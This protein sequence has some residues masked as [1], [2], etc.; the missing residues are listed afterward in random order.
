MATFTRTDSLGTGAA[1]GRSAET[2][3]TSGVAGGRTLTSPVIQPVNG[4]A[5]AA[6]FNQ[7][8]TKYSENF[9]PFIQK[10]SI[11]Q[12]RF[13]HDRIPR[14]A[15]TLFSGASKE[16]RIFRGG[17]V[18]YAGLAHWGD[19]VDYASA[20]GSFNGQTYPDLMPDPVTYGYS[21]EKLQW[22]GK[23]MA[24]AS[25]PIHQDMFRFTQE[26]QTQLA[27]ILQSGID[28]AFSHQE[29]WNRDNYIYAAVQSG[30]AFIMAPGGESASV[31]GQFYYN[32]YSYGAANVVDTN[33]HPIYLSTVPHIVF[34]VDQE[35]EPLNF[36]VLD[37]AHDALSVRA[38][39]GGIGMDSGKPVFGLPI[40][41][42][43]FEKYV[44]G[45]AAELEAWRQ[46]YPQELIK[47]YGM[48]LKNYRY[49]GLVEDTNQ[50]RFKI[51]KVVTAEQATWAGITI[52]GNSA[53]TKLWVAEYVA[54]R[55]LGRNSTTSI[56]VPEENMDYIKAELAIS[57]IFMNNVFT[58]Q[59]VPA[60]P[61]LGSGTSF[62]A[63]PGLNGNWGWQN[64]LDKTTNPH[65]KVGNFYGT[66]EIFP[67]P[68]SNF[69]NAT[70]FLYRRCTES[71][72]SRCPVN[73]DD[74]TASTANIV[75]TDVTA[76]VAGEVI[77]DALVEI[78]LT[79]TI[80]ATIGTPVS[81][82]VKDKNSADGVIYGVIV[83]A[84]AAPTYTVA[85]TDTNDVD[86]SGTSGDT[87]F[88]SANFPAT[89]AVTVL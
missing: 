14:G 3:A 86:G 41:M 24:W 36:D 81:I 10:S 29:V 26:A 44:K 69:V 1:F 35:V 48:L 51:A 56:G 50:L 83:K 78:K 82:A 76:A 31:K 42:R 33:G 63:Q 32:P 68:E 19:V 22:G 79:K 52:F 21:W 65:G 7:V 47:G 11:E 66:Y 71:L 57:P 88:T 17:L 61:D 15:Y 18:H 72:R 27:W 89:G 67:K 53:A 59:F 20:T 13:W 64:I 2:T 23:N 37:F 43:D 6:A 75:S 46:A 73:I 38:P 25:D 54:P 34:P 77:A 55:K 85:V 84:S 62:G 74:D 28:F 4:T 9:D 30:R 80:D 8:M 49:Y 5:A 12:P 87:Y 45:N 60:T 70:A 39:A 58:N 40:S 16:T